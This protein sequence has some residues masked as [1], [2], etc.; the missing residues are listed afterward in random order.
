M[1]SLVIAILCVAGL[2]AAALSGS[3]LWGEREGLLNASGVHCGCLAGKGECFLPCASCCG[4]GGIA[5]C[6]S[7]GDPTASAPRACH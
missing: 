5:A 6:F 3:T 7:N 1:R 2:A 4:E